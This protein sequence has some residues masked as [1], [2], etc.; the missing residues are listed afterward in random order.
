LRDATDEVFRRFH[1]QPFGTDQSEDH[2]L[3]IWD[4]SERFKRARPIVIVFEEKPGCTGAL[5]NRPGDWLIVAF[6][7][8]TAFLV[9]ATEVDG[10][11]HAIKS[12]H[13]GVVEI[14]S[15]TQPLIKR[16]TLRFIKSPGLRREE[17]RVVRR[18]DLYVRGTKAN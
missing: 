5:E 11:G 10:E 3:I 1:L 13:N 9:A 6:D 12:G 2:Y 17:Q 14:N 7:E 4:V 18:V 16:P 15:P 8:P